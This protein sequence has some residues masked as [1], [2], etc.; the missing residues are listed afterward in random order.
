MVGIVWNSSLTGVG[1][2]NLG[3]L[4]SFWGVCR[5]RLVQYKTY[6]EIRLAF[7]NTQPTLVEVRVRQLSSDFLD[8]L[9]ML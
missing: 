7:S 2:Q 3:V 1:D 5:N 6:R 4:Y 8:D 9:N